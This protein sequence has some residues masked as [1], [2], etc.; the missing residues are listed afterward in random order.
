MCRNYKPNRNDS[1]RMRYYKVELRIVDYQSWEKLT[2]LQPYW[3]LNWQL[4]IRG[5]TSRNGTWMV[6]SRVA[7]KKLIAWQNSFPD[8][9]R[10]RCIFKWRQRGLPHAKEN[11][12]LRRTHPIFGPCSKLRHV[13][14]CVGDRW[15]CEPRL[16]N[17]RPG[18]TALIFWGHSHSQH[19]WRVGP[20][21]CIASLCNFRVGSVTKITDP[22]QNPLHDWS[23]LIR[24]F[25]AASERSRSI[26]GPLP[27]PQTVVGAKFAFSRVKVSVEWP[28]AL[29]NFLS[30]S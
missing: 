10:K 8:Q 2:L 26:F 19:N 23:V 27:R 3:I 25:Q 22:S 13:L 24:D 14:K 4:I 28:Y 12:Q 11:G 18:T 20:D 17:K 5:Q 21:C 6:R 16:P 9:L 30:V 15:R 29:G 7:S 1:C